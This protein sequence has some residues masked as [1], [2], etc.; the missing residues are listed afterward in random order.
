VIIAITC[1]VSHA[2]WDKIEMLLNPDVSIIVE[3]G[4]SLLLTSGTYTVYITPV[5]ALALAFLA[6]P[7]WRFGGRALALCYFAMTLGLLTRL[8]EAI[9]WQQNLSTWTR[10][11]TAAGTIYDSLPPLL[12]GAMLLHPVIAHKLALPRD[13]SRNA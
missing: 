11:H 10:L 2:P 9:V 6:V 5:L 13:A 12:L 8:E 1:G 7:R 3:T 4:H